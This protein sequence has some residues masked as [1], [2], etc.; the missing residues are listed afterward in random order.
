MNARVHALARE[1]LAAPLPGVTDIV[2]SYTTLY[3]EYDRGRLNERAVRAWAERKERHATETT[4]R[5]VTVPVR[6]DG[7]DLATIAAEA[8]LE[9]AEVIRRHAAV[10]YRVY[11]LGFTGGFPFMG[12]VDP[13]IRSPRLEVPRE[14]VEANSV[15]IADAQGGIYPLAAPGGWKLVGTALDPV[16]DPHR[17]HPFLF[18]AGDAVRFVPADGPTPAAAQPLELLPL[19]PLQPVL[20]VL[21][22]GLLDIVVDAGRFMAGRFGLARSGPADFRSAAL[23][24]RLLANSPSAPLLELNV[25]GPVLEALVP[26]VVAFAGWGVEPLKNGE[27]REPFRSFAL[28]PGDVLSFPPAQH[29]VRGYLAIPGG[30]ESDTFL[31]S[32]SVD[33]RGLIGRPLARADVLGSVGARRPRPGFSFQPHVR[34]AGV[35]RIRL[36]PGPQSSDDAMR[37]LTSAVFRVRFSDRMGMRLDGPEVPGGGVLSEANPLGAVQ[38]T[39]SGVPLVLLQDRG[40]IGGYSKPAIVHPKDLPRLAQLRAGGEVVFELAR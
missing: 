16:Y 29:G 20:R 12:E 27:P 5:T 36:V 31:G 19:E 4:G 21:E 30:I 7:A 13:T 14:R 9:V 1:L 32:A 15:A 10:D 17:E 3:L 39:A 22:P 28:S 40:T 6:Y 2:P 37:A 11:A 33:V 26:T 8:G 18:E 24:N 34:W 35:T 38:V 25:R 23:A